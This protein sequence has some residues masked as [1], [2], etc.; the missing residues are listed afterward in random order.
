[1]LQRKENRNPTVSDI[2]AERK[3]LKEQRGGWLTPAD[4]E[5]FRNRI[6]KAKESN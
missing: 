4:E 6:K 1:M 5:Y 2:E 3:L